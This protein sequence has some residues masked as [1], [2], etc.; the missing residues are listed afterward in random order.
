MEVNRPYAYKDDVLGAKQAIILLEKII[1][2]INPK[3][4]NSYPAILPKG[5]EIYLIN[6]GFNEEMHS[7]FITLFLPLYYSKNKCENIYV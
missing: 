7:K 3:D 6:R 5:G 4:M 2:E 1:E